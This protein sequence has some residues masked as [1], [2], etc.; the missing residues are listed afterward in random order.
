LDQ[1]RPAELGELPVRDDLEDPAAAH[2]LPGMP[3]HAPARRVPLGNDHR[4]GEADPADG[5]PGDDL[6]TDSGPA[7]YLR[8]G[9]PLALAG[10]VHGHL[11]DPLGRRPDLRL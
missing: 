5:G 3:D 6:G 1:L 8:T 4:V 7:A 10:P 11:P 2:D 9:D